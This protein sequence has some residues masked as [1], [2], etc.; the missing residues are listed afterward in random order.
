[1]HDIPCS[2]KTRQGVLLPFTLHKKAS[3]TYS[4]SLR[5][6]HEL[7][8][9]SW[10]HSCCSPLTKH[11]KLLPSYSHRPLPSHPVWSKKSRHCLTR[12]RLVS[13]SSAQFELPKHPLLS[14]LEQSP[15]ELPP[16]VVV[17][18]VVAVTSA[19]VVVVTEDG[20]LVVVV[21][22]PAVVVPAAPSLHCPNPPL[23]SHAHFSAS[24][25]PAPVQ[26]SRV[27]YN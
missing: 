9:N 26:A 12:Q 5:S 15:P 3:V 13:W 11:T 27:A 20:P 7:A 1:M 10:L 6:P 21:L 8:S 16:V 4:Q 2:K 17:V 19:V 18:V 24:H 14:S 22:P 23:S 25:A